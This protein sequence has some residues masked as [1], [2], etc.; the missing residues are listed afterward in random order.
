MKKSTLIKIFVTTIAIVLALGLCACSKK[1]DDPVTPPASAQTVTPSAHTHTVVTDAA[2]APTCTTSGMTQGSHC[3]TCNEVIKAQEFIKPFGHTEVVDQAVAPTCTE[4]GKTQ[5]SHCST[6][7]EV[8]KAQEFIKPFGHTEVIDKAVDPTCTTTGLTSGKHCSVCNEVIKAQEYVKP[9]GHTEVVDQAVDPSCTTSGK[10][11]GSHCS[12]CSAV[13]MVQQTVPQLGHSLANQTLSQATCISAGTIKYSCS[14]SYCNYSYT[15]TFSLPIYSATELYDQAI[16]YVGEIVTYDK[17]GEKYA[18]GTGFVIS[19]DGK[20]VTNYH[21]IE[22]AY[23]AEITINNVTYTISSVLAYDANIDLAVLKINA[24]GLTYA[25]VCKN[26]VK[27]G[28]TVYAIGSSKGLTNT[29]SQGIITQAQRVIDGVVHIQHDAAISSGNSGGPLL[30]VYGEVIGVNK[31]SR[32]DSQNINMAVFTTEF[33]NL[34]YGTPI[35]LAQLYEQNM[36]AYDVLVAWLIDNY[37]YRS[38][39]TIRYEY[40]SDNGSTI[41]SLAYN[42]EYDYLFVDSYMMF[43]DGAKAYFLIDLS[44]DPSQYAYFATYASKNGENTTTGYFNAATYTEAAELTYTS[45]EGYEWA[46]TAMMNFHAAHMYSVVLFLDDFTSW[47]DQN[48]NTGI[49][50]YDLGFKVWNR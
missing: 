37:N 28:E 1:T 13:L 30:N 45:F 33:D 35:T 47:I 26:D 14:R 31:M 23:S 4:S 15:E 50:I 48:Y 41:V 3:S 2:V 24:T 5:G 29:F 18:I 21:V 19:S 34:V 7:S 32:V 46:E 11:Q 17:S 16:K 38:D 36:S 40:I 8:I 44:F 12:V 10:T 9:S 27:T 6:C 25:K 22:G 42:F 43:D 49:T 39:T 20:I